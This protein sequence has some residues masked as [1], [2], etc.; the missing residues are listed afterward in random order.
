MTFIIRTV[1]AAVLLVASAGVFAAQGLTPQQ[2]DDYPFVPTKGP[3]THR[4]IVQEL[5][6]LEAVGYQP[7]IDDPLYPEGLNEA[8]RRLWKE[9]ARDCGASHLSTA[10]TDARN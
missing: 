3:I 9:Y 2:C 10:M 8:Q 7:S 4:Q 6:E 1:S 5:A